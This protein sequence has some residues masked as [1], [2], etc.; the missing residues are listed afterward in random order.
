ID[1]FQ[2]KFV[3]SRNI[4]VWLPDNY[5][6]DKKYCVLYLQDGQMLFDAETTWNKQSWEI[7]ETISKL[8]KSHT[9][10]DVI[11]VAIYNDGATRHYD[12][13]PQKPFESLT[14]AQKNEIFKKNRANGV[15]V[16]S[17]PKINSDNYLKFIVKELK[18][19]IDNKYSVHADFKHTFIG[20]SSMGGLIS[21]Y[22]ICEYP[23]IFGGAICMSTH[24]PGIFE[25]ENN[26]IPQAFFNYLKLNLPNP[27]NHKIYF[28]YGTETLDKMYQTLQPKADHIMRMKK[29]N[30]KNW[31]TKK[32]EGDD[33]SELSWQKRFYIPLEFM[34]SKK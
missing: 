25:L 7:D 16:F 32:F 1:N 3:T 2:S 33:H 29:Y 34:L 12:Y 15:A 10:K 22:A 5:S 24:W 27:K 23:T 11:V 18:P 28:D 9:I 30:S 14:S 8:I 20:G 19:L 13:F 17:V 6:I 26:P 4:D 31:L 21:L